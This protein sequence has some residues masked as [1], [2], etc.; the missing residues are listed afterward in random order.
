MAMIGRTNTYLMVDAERLE[1]ESRRAG[2]GV[3]HC[4]IPFMH[5]SRKPCAA[6]ARDKAKRCFGGRGGTGLCL[7]GLQGDAAARR[8]VALGRA[9]LQPEDEIEK[10]SC[11]VK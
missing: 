10:G 9:S 5:S 11:V 7:A 4:M 3:T 2:A 8:G 1:R 6:S